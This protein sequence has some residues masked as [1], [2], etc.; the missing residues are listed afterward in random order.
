VR[1]QWQCVAGAACAYRHALLPSDAALVDRQR[2]QANAARDAERA[3][4]RDPLCETA[5]ASK[6]SRHRLFAEWLAAEFSHAELAHVVDVAGGKGLIS[7]ALLAGAAAAGDDAE[8]RCTVLDPRKARPSAA[9]LRRSAAAAAA[10]PATAVQYQAAELS[11]SGADGPAVAAL[12]DTAS[13]LVGMHSDEATEAIVDAGLRLGTPFAVVPCCAFPS[14]FPDRRLPGGAKV[15]TTADLVEYL[16]AKAPGGRI[17]EG[18]LPFL[19]RNTVVFWRPEG[20]GG[21]R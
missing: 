14:M 2:A 15:A 19:G 4:S 21:P 7:L 11:P 20:G 5:K 13:L 16:K 1:N 9:A 8:R 10:A 18:F 17:K 6:G 3:A 12:L